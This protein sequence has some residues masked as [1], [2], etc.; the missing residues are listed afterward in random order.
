MS[1][2]YFKN[3]PLVAYKGTQ[4][5]N[6]LLKASII[7]DLF[8]D[9]TTFYDYFVDDGEKATH[10]A[11]NY[12][13]SVDYAWLVFLSN[14]IMDPYFE[15][16]LSN[17]EFEQYIAKKYGSV[18]EAYTEVVEYRLLSDGVYTNKNISV[19]TKEYYETI[20]L[21]EKYTFQPVYAYDKEFE[22]NEVKRKIKLIDKKYATRI[23]NELEKALSQ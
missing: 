14:R 9:D 4:L 19:R 5:R 23:S 2:K 20:E 8:L 22:A 6:I 11:F 13:G 12:Y 7:R 18:Q 17:E 10:V 15:W 1:S 21:P 16:Y 3:F